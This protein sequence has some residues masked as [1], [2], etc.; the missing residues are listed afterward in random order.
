MAAEF[1]GRGA[2]RRQHFL[3]RVS[4]F[5]VGCLLAG[6]CGKRAVVHR[7][8]MVRQA[9]GICRQVRIAQT[10]HVLILCRPA[11]RG[12]TYLGIRRQ[13]GPGHGLWGGAASRPGANISSRSEPS[14]L[15]YSSVSPTV[16]ANIACYARRILSRR[17]FVRPVRARWGFGR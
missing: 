7:R 11:R 6:G 17:I 2:G 10:V 16:R 8:K 13:S 15:Q 14:G 4:S 1:R 3:G 9:A 5:S 12:S